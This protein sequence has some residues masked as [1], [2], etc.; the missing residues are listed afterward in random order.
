MNSTIAIAR[1]SLQMIGRDRQALIA[2]LSFPLIFVLAFSLFDMQLLG[3]ALTG[4]ADGG[5]AYFDFVLPGLIAMNVMQFS[6]LWT[7][8]GVTRFREMSILKR[9]AATPLR[10]IGFISGQVVAR[11]MFAVVL[12]LIIL[13][14]GILLGA[15]VV[16][17][18]GLIVLLVV[19]GN[20]VFVSLGFAA[21][22]RASSVDTATTMASLVTMPMAFLSGVFFPVEAM[23]EF[24][25]QAVEW[26]PLTPL[27]DA[28]RAVSLEG[29]GF[30]EIAGDIGALLAWLPVMLTVAALNFRFSERR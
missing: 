1:A 29:A 3:T 10:P 22:G 15:A 16:G 8:A 23:P 30:G 4:D 14:G 11:A 17:G 5:Y 2:M 25:Q 21:A 24:M 26:L 9:L 7:A 13:G 18:I 27:L 19:L 20:L 12:A 28:M 6:V